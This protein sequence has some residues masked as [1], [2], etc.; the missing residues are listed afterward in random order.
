MDIAKKTIALLHRN[1]SLHARLNQLKQ[2]TNAFVSSVM[3]NPENAKLNESEPPADKTS[4]KPKILTIKNQWSSSIHADGVQSHN[5]F[6]YCV[7]NHIIFASNEM[8]LQYYNSALCAPWLYQPSVHSQTEQT[9]A[10]HSKT[11]FWFKL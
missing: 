11:F 9:N 7:Q 3:A 6:K 1:R 5:L 10:R 8:H 2:E 4:E